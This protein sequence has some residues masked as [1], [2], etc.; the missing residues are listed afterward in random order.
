M[1]TKE[2]VARCTARLSAQW[3][4]VP[5][6]QLDEVARELLVLAERQLSEP[7]QVATLW[8]RQGIPDAGSAG[9]R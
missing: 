5:D 7:E 2:W 4:R 6:E 3:P 9:E 1:E 8:L